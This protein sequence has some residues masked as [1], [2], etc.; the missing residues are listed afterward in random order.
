[1]SACHNRMHI[2]EFGNAGNFI[3]LF[4]VFTP[5]G[6]VIW[7]RPSSVPASNTFSS[8]RLSAKDGHLSVDIRAAIFGHGIYAPYLAH[9]RDAVAV[10]AAAEVGAD[11]LPAAPAVVA[12][13]DK[14]RR[15]V[16]PLVIVAAHLQ[17]GIPIPAK[18]RL[19]DFS[20]F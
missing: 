18:G 10:D 3:Y 8:R 14:L 9:H 2:A 19:P 16:N 13:E 4:P 6:L 17:R 12:A 20:T 7:M 1:V 5:V 11:G 15:M